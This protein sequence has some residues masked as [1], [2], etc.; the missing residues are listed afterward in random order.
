MTTNNTIDVSKI[1]KL[2]EPKE[3][4]KQH[5]KYGVMGLYLGA[6]LHGRLKSFAALKGVKMSTI[7]I[8][9]LKEYLNQKDA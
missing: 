6:E 2:I 8:A 1:D 9:L 4:I 7:V 5:R 3:H